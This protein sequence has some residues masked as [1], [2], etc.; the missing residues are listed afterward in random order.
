MYWMSKS[1]CLNLHEFAIELGKQKTKQ[2]AKTNYVK[3]ILLNMSLSSWIWFDKVFCRF[4]WSIL[5]WQ[6]KKRRVFFWKVFS[7]TVFISI[8]TQRCSNYTS[9][10]LEVVLG[11]FF[12]VSVLFFRNK[13]LKC[14]W[15]LISASRMLSLAV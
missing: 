1:L 13:T 3:W 11:F 10:L 6:P 14:F 9:T 12:C 5:T 8:T 2:I 4:F 7:L 15:L